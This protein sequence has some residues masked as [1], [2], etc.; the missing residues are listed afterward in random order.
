MEADRFHFAM[1][2]NFL[3]A[4]M[5]HFFFRAYLFLFRWLLKVDNKESGNATYR[6]H[7][8]D[9]DDPAVGL[10]EIEE[11]VRHVGSLNLQIAYKS[12]QDTELIE[13]DT[14]NCKRCH[15]FQNEQQHSEVRRTDD[16]AVGYLVA[17]QLLV[18]MPSRKE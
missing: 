14:A 11:I 8:K 5:L 17:E 7:S 13:Y 10:R 9:D 18:K 4:G 12:E 1:T 15:I 16:A 3:L 6:Y 2:G